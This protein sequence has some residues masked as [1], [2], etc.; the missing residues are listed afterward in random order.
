VRNFHNSWCSETS[1]KT[2]FK[3]FKNV[4]KSSDVILEVLDARDPLG[5]RSPTIEKQILDM[6]PNKKIVLVLNKVD[7]IPK[8]NM[9]AW[10]TY[11]RNEFPVVG[12]KCSTQKI[13]R[14]G[15]TGR[16]SVS[17]AGVSGDQMQVTS[18][19]IGA[20]T[21]ISL[22]KNYARSNDIKTNIN[23]GIIGFPNVGKSSLINSLKREKVVGVGAKAGFTRATQEV[24][25]DKNITLIDCPGIIFATD[26]SES[27]A[28]LRN[29]INP[30]QLSDFNLPIQAILHRC[31]SSHLAQI[32][33]IPMFSDVNEFLRHIAVKR[34]QIKQ[35][36]IAAIDQ[37]ARLVLQDWNCGK[38]PYYTIPPE[39]DT[40]KLGA[41][42]VPT[43][44]QLF[45]LNEVVEL[46]K[47]ELSG[48]MN[49][50]VNFAFASA[51]KTST[52]IV[53]DNMF[54][55]LNKDDKE[56][57]P[58]EN[59]S[60][61]EEEDE[62]EEH[63]DQD[64]SAADEKAENLGGEMELEKSTKK[65]PLTAIAPVREKQQPPKK[66]QRLDLP[67]AQQSTELRN[68]F[69]ELQKEKKK[70]DKQ[71]QKEKEA[72]DYNFQ[73]DFWTSNTTATT[74]ST[75]GEGSF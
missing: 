47:R 43:W 63:N 37:S 12:F 31:P 49:D 5:S 35:G 8:S 60:R 64:I 3:Q 66:K 44:S 15:K 28:A 71:I 36:G 39:P 38:I 34:G 42:I 67:V 30:E 51:Q 55:V 48:V 18:Q 75:F 14:R 70:K 40:L 19:C 11:L 1:K 13:T 17:T 7:L 16:S 52:S 68:Q 27:D 62:G 32:Y 6:D 58:D 57:H 33:G 59:M 73:S 24:Y 21:L 9:D 23:V 2:F 25:L 22:L 54:L 10:L 45:N 26:M 20:E 4:V 50:D 41:S 72:Q 29:C 53:P 74:A 61:E 56:E 46:E 69:K 65:K